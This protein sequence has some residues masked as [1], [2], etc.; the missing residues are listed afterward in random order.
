MRRAH[1]DT[2]AADGEACAGYTPAMSASADPIDVLGLGCATVD[3]LIYLPHH[4]I[5]ERKLRIEG[6][7]RHGGGVVATAI[8]AAAR[9]GARAAW[10]GVLGD[11]ELSRFVRRGFESAGVDCAFIATEPGAR[12]FHSRVLI[13]RDTRTRSVLFSRQGERWP[14]PGTVDA[15]LLAR[16]RVLFVDHYGIGSDPG[17]V[18]RA[19]DAGVPVVADI[20]RSNVDGV[21][22]AIPA[23]DHLILP[24]HYA[25]ELTGVATAAEAVSALWND[26]RTVVAVTDGAAGVWYTSRDVSGEQSET[27]HFPAYPV[28]LVD[29][30][31][32]G[33]VFHGVYAAGLAA[34]L[35]LERRLR[36]AAAAA[37]IKAT[38]IGAQS[39][40]PARS[41]IDAFLRERGEDAGARG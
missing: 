25:R 10:L 26:R 23:I 29:P 5:E 9:D 4:P 38:R 32:C 31:G 15:A 37:A 17:V 8:V 1:V 36:R 14:P 11:D 3:E 22:E 30:T 19:R 39:G 6:E 27:R 35:P 16:V 21:P 13:A 34:G 12:P 20:E 7:E 33:D 24:A 40:A 2:D 18:G 28:E 41:E